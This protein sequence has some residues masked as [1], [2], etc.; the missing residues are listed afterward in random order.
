MKSKNRHDF[1]AITFRFEIF[2]TF[3]NLEIDFSI[4]LSKSLLNVVNDFE[5]IVTSDQNF[6][7]L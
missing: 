6:E 1:G 7:E 3:R 4:R 5:V 2:Q